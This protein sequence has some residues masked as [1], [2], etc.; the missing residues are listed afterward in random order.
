MNPLRIAV[1]ALVIAL[2]AALLSGPAAAGAIG[3]SPLFS[4][5]VPVS[6]FGLARNW[7]D[8]SRLHVSSMVSVGSS[9]WGSRGTS[10]LQVTT[11]SYSFKA[12]VAMSVSLGNAW[13]ANT[14]RSGQSLYLQGFSLAF[15]PSHA[16]QFQ[17][18]YQDLRSPLQ[19]QQPGFGAPGRWGY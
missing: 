6:A 1:P 16:T 15:R 18:Q 19:Y 4:P 3:G 7:F 5:R 12:P 17:I 13:G 14:A 9:S 2:L 11:L 10:A 8:P